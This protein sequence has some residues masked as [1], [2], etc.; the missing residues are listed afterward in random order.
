[1]YASMKYHRE[2]YHRK[3]KYKALAGVDRNGRRDDDIS[4]THP[5][6]KND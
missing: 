4:R 3:K 5:S 2:T 6:T 1:M